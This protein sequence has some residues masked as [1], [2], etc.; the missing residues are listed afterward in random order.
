MNI[1]YGVI[2]LNYLSEI[3]AF[4]RWLETNYLP[5]SSQL[6]WYKLMMLFNRSGWAEWIPASNQRLMLLIQCSD[7]KKFIDIRNRLIDT[8]LIKYQRG[9]K[10]SPSKYKGLFF[11]GNTPV[12]MPVQIPVNMP[13]QIP[14]IKKEKDKD[15]KE[16]ITPAPSS[17]KQSKQK[18]GE[19]KHVSLTDEEKQK[20]I[21]EYGEATTQQAIKTL[22]EYMEMNGRQYKSCYL[23]IRKW[24]IKA[25]KQ[26][27]Q[28]TP[29]CI[30]KKGLSDKELEKRRAL[31]AGMG[32]ETA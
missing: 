32:D 20:L 19:Y 8:G 23:A 29:I 27:Q 6:L 15:K 30:A 21:A 28:E 5:A 18:Y 24:V 12:Q 7:E 26:E 22:D 2:H 9:K 25:V 13:A 4:E 1:E 31:I 14:D 3:N 11:T 10:G 17:S 16:S